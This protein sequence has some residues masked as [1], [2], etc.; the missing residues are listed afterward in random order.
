MF[1]NEYRGGSRKRNL[2]GFQRWFLHG[3]PVEV[4][5]WGVTKNY[6]SLGVDL[7][8]SGYL[9]KPLAVQAVKDAWEYCSGTLRDCSLHAGSRFF[10]M[11][12]PRS[13]LDAML[14]GLKEMILCGDY[15]YPSLAL[16]ANAFE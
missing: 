6:A 12:I 10:H 14:A 11:R 13:E 3:R 7:T 9:L 2:T 1:H 4:E 5:V 16:D 8:L 15:V